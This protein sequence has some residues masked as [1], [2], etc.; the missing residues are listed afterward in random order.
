MPP[1]VARAIAALVRVD[2]GYGMVTKRLAQLD[3]QMSGL[4]GSMGQIDDLGR[5]LATTGGVRP[6]S[7][8]LGGDGAS[9]APARARAEADGVRRQIEALEQ[10]HAPSSEIGQ[11]RSK[12]DQI[13]RALKATREGAPRAGKDTGPAG[14]DL[15]GLLRGD[16]TASTDLYALAQAARAR[17]GAS[18][19]ALAKDPPRPP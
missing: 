14:T 3:Q 12:L 17:L 13:E 11:L 8:G 7:E 15:P 1:D 2:S 6:T 4:R 9:D 19:P 10:A 18:R 16:R 5:T